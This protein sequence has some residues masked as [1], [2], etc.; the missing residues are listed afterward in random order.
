MTVDERRRRGAS[1][2]DDFTPA[3]IAALFVLL[4]A[5]ASIPVLTHKLPPLADYINHL[6]RTHIIHTIDE[7]PFLARFY[8]IDWAV[9]PNLMIDL[10]VPLLDRV[11]TVYAAG[12]VFTVLAFLL[13]V[14]GTLVL[15]RALFGRWSALPLIAI[16]L[17]YNGVMLVGVMNYVF[18]I[19]LAIWMLAGWVVLRARAL[20]LRLAASTVFV[21]VLFF[22]HLFAVGIYALGILAF[23]LQRLWMR[24]AEPL[25]PRLL[26]FAASGMPFLAVALLFFSGPTPET[27]GFSAD[28]EIQ[29]KLH[30]LL[31]A[32]NVYYPAVGFALLAVAILIG[33]YALRVGALRFHPLGWTMLGVGLLIYLA[34]PRVLLAAHLADQRLPIALAFLLIACFSLELRTR[35]I[36]YVFVGALALVVSMRVIEV[37]AVWDDLSSRTE[38]F[39]KSVENIERGSRVLVVHGSGGDSEEITNADLVHAASIATIERSALVTTAFTVPGK[40]I[41]RVREEFEDLVET[42]DRWPPSLPYVLAHADRPDPKNDYFWELWPNHYDYV[43]ILF[44]RRGAQCPDRKHLTLVHDGPGFQLYR[45]TG[46]NS[47][48]RWGN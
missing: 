27:P 2:A 14:S 23:E 37:Q 18:G 21:V 10:V 5:A 39:Q 45:V 25:W 29:G 26:D 4:M 13:I 1:T 35:A 24:R 46:L 3:A 34:M 20:P 6:A 44:T 28:W 38:E 16:P 47:E 15:N 30:G 22:C 9:I 17:L 33:A 19:G 11:M 7:D 32:I 43:Y 48:P 42:E 31:L 12:Q 36:R 41:L 40:H 8:A